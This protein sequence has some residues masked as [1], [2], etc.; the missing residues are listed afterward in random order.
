MIFYRNRKQPGKTKSAILFGFSLIVCVLSCSVT[1]SQ[2][3]IK[4]KV[5]TADSKLPVLSAYIYL[6]NTSFGSVTDKNGDFEIKH[7]LNGKYELIISFVG[8]EV[9][10]KSIIISGQIDVGQISIIPKINELQEVIVMPYMKDGWEKYGEIF[11]NNFIGVSQ[12]SQE[13]KIINRSVLK[14]NLNKRTNT[15][16]ATASEPLIIENRA[17]GYI[18][19]YDLSKF[20]YNIDEKTFLY[21]GTGFFEEMT[22]AK[23]SQNRK[24]IE[25]RME[26]YSG[27]LMHFM[28]SL[29]S[30]SL[31]EEQFVVRKMLMLTAGEKKRVDSIVK[32][33]KS[34]RPDIATIEEKDHKFTTL[35]S[36]KP[37]QDTLEYY[38]R[39]KE[40]TVGYDM[41]LDPHLKPDE[42]GIK[43]DKNG[44][45]LINS[46]KLFV[47]YLPKKNLPEYQKFLLRL[48]IDQEVGSRIIPIT[49]VPISVYKEGMFFDGNDINIS[50]Y[51][52]WFEKICN[53]LPYDY[54]PLPNK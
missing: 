10:K 54:Y 44:L 3:S 4:G 37:Y 24:W 29:Y 16:K 18:I 5:I 19:K 47:I 33:I 22:A 23:V 45:L 11:I 27:S 35:R 48:K 28:R 49:G 36:G 14:F 15:V 34:L 21:G 1:Y 51:W 40:S 17:L 7:V 50:G 31:T 12:F 39:V 38:R 26:A 8:Y 13:C 30:G 32:K 53:K 42:I 6:N 2:S 43:N 20:E 52:S 9:V 46:E 25:N 41:I